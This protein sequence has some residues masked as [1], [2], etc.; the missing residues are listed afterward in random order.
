[1]DALKQLD[2]I[3][4]MVN[5]G[6]DVTM[7]E[8]GEV[9]STEKQQ[10]E[11]VKEIVSNQEVEPKEVILPSDW[12]LSDWRQRH[13]MQLYKTGVPFKEEFNDRFT[14]NFEWVKAAIECDC[15]ERPLGVDEETLLDLEWYEVE[16]IYNAIRSHLFNLI[17]LKKK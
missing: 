8:D 15:F 2:Q 4:T 5:S 10:V 14:R 13:L 17:T 12:K 6:Q 1:M 3:A 9:V 11:A 16:E 7:N